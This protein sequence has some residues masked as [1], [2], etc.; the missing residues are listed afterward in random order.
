MGEGDV[1]PEVEELLRSIEALEQEF[2][3]GA[4]DERDYR[5]LHDGYTVRVADLIRRTDR[6]SAA[7]YGKRPVPGGEYRGSSG[8]EAGA[9]EAS[10]GGSKSHGRRRLAVTAVGAVAFAIGSGVLLAQA[11][12]ER[13]LGATLTGDSVSS[14]QRIFDCQQLGGSGDLPAS[15]ECLDQVLI[16]SPDSA[17]ALAYRGWFTVLTVGSA[18]T[19][20]EDAATELLDIGRTFV[21]RA[22]ETDPLLPDARA[23][24]A[25]IFDRRGEAGNACAEIEALLALDPPPFFV[26]Q[27]SGIAERNDC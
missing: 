21:D 23:F 25:A 2:A 4:L 14:R 11:V 24:S 5:S 26:R 12:G 18:S 15:I 17:E 13:R 9:T 7:A 22:V 3:A 10:A 27:T 19:P 8:G 1:D 6:S 20:D 16:D